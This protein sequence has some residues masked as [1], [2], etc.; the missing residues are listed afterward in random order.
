MARNLRQFDENDFRN[1]VLSVAKH[2]VFMDNSLNR[3][4][5]TKIS[6]S[7]LKAYCLKAMSCGP[8]AKWIPSDIQD[9]FDVSFDPI[10]SHPE[11]Y[12]ENSV[13]ISTA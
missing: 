10:G 7:T 3:N 5:R 13:K 12:I 11:K 9:D 4:G 8:I 1:Y 2:R 6:T